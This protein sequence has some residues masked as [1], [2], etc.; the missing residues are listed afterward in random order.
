MFILTW[1]YFSRVNIASHTSTDIALV[2][3]LVLE[4]MLL[5]AF[6]SALNNEVIPRIYIAWGVAKS[7]C[8]ELYSELCSL[9]LTSIKVCALSTMGVTLIPYV[10][11]WSVY[12]SYHSLWSIAYYVCCYNLFMES[13]RLTLQ[14]LAMLAWLI[15]E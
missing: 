3:L 2:V 11:H 14:T 10:T 13:A 1:N 8:S 9:K 5:S 7:L 15:M 12:R 6:T 4:T